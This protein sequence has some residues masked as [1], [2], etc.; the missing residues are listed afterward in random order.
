VSRFLWGEVA[1]HPSNDPRRPFYGRNSVL[2]VG[3]SAGGSGTHFAKH[4]P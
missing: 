1:D 4:L 2:K 3:E